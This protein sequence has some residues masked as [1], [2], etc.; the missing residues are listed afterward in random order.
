MPLQRLAPW[1]IIAITIFSLSMALSAQFMFQLEPCI[2]CLYQRLPYVATGLLALLAL[3]LTP[4]SPAIAVIVGLCALAY[5]AGGGIA[6]YHVGVEQHWWVSGCTGNSAAELTFD[7]IKAAL[8]AKAEKSCDDVDWTLF[9]ISMATYNV[10]FSLSVGLIA[11]IAAHRIRKD[12]E[13]EKTDPIPTP[14]R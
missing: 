8:T 4:D 9:G 7:Q 13:P 2:L 11:M 14:A 5:L 6:I 3:R 1:L 10:V 12:H